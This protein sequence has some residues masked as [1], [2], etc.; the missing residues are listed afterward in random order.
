MNL[1]SD[2]ECDTLDAGDGQATQWPVPA[3][4]NVAASPKEHLMAVQVDGDI[5]R[6]A[7][8]N[9]GARGATLIA[10][11][12]AHAPTA[13]G[14]LT[15]EQSAFVCIDILTDTVFATLDAAD[16]SPLEGTWTGVSFAA[17]SRLYGNFI[18]IDLASGSCIAYRGV[19]L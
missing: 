8:E 10:D 3:T 12:A 18:A 9:V 19:R 5:V 2:A 13:G 6:F 7:R 4:S 14:G 1:T 17:G 15:A 16:A 11:T